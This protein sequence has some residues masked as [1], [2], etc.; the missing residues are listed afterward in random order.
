MCTAT[1]MLGGMYLQLSA[2][3]IVDCAPNIVNYNGCNGG[4]I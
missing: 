1:Y 2:Q 3:Q 4:L